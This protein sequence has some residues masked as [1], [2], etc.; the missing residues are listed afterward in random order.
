M[1]GGIEIFIIDLFIPRLRRGSVNIQFRIIIDLFT[2]RLR[3]GEYKYSIFDDNGFIHPLSV[4]CRNFQLTMT[5]VLFIP[6]LRRVSVNIQ[7]RM[8]MDLFSP[9]LKGGEFEYSIHE[10]NAIIH[11]PPE[12]GG[13]KILNL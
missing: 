2:P 4:G 8:I 11:P 9:R 3:R 12:R 1:R 6:P 13:I 10:D 7:F 5:M